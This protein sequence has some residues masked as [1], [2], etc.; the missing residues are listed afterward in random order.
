M[1][2]C[3]CVYAYNSNVGILHIA[4][5]H[6]MSYIDSFEAI[7][8]RF[9]PDANQ[10]LKIT[11][12]NECEHHMSICCIWCN[13]ILYVLNGSFL[14]D[15]YAIIW[16]I[17][18]IIRIERNACSNGGNWQNGFNIEIVQNLCVGR[19]HILRLWTLSQKEFTRNMNYSFKAPGV[20]MAHRLF[21]NDIP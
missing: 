20:H 17:G 19:G 9:F 10:L 16:K 4:K 21:E 7:G 6:P 12:L 11:R 13:F 5:K 2:V 1:C 8:M 3:V 14:A 18:W 15:A